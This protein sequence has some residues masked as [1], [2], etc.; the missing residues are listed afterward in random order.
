M[1]QIDPSLPDESTSQTTE[2]DATK[3][4]LEAKRQEQMARKAAKSAEKL[5]RSSTKKLSK[6]EKASSTS[7]SPADSADKGG[8]AGLGRLAGK[9]KNEVEVSANRREIPIT[10]FDLLNGSFKK[11]AKVRSISVIVVGVLATLELIL[12]AQGLTARIQL[13]GTEKS[14]TA[15]EAEG[16]TVLGTFGESTGIEGV[17]ETEII[18]RERALTVALRKAVLAQPDL[19]GLYSDLRKFDGLGVVVTGVSVSDGAAAA[20]AAQPS[21]KDKDDTKSA[22]APAPAISSLV[23]ISADGTDF[24]Q[25]VAWTKRVQELPQL[26]NVKSSRQGLK[27]TITAFIAPNYVSSA[28]ADL[29]GSLGIALNT[30]TAS[31]EGSN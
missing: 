12:G 4:L 31:T 28:G 19:S 3:A 29:L 21:E 22:P 2:R 27:I 10:G 25:I 15:I 9:G 11:S 23:T 20:A 8:K 14:I 1:S 18:D 13:S 5:E 30:T 17:T 24:G 6:S 16:S 26:V 7:A